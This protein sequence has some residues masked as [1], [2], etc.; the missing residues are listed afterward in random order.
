MHNLRFIGAMVSEFR[1]FKKK[2]NMANLIKQRTAMDRNVAIVT[3]DHSGAI[4]MPHAY[5]YADKINTQREDH[6]R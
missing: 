5:T 4:N 6:R 3:F 1:F 2:K